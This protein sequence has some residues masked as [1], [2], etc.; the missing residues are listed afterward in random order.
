MWIHAGRSAK[1]AGVG[2]IKILETMH[3]PIR[4]HGALRAAS[5]IGQDE[6]KWI[7]IKLANPDG[8][9]SGN[10]PRSSCFSKAGPRVMPG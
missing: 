10:F 5:P 3:A 8:N 4:I 2:D 9:T 1:Q 7:V 6:N